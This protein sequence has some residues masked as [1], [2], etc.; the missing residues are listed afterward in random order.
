[1][2]RRLLQLDLH[3]LL[4]PSPNEILAQT[5]VACAAQDMICSIYTHPIGFFGHAPGPTIG[6]WDDQ[7]G[8]PVRGDWLL[9]PN[10]CYAIEGNVKSPVGAWGEQMVQIKLEQTACFD[11]ERVIYLAGR[12]TRWH[13]VR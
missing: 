8:T 5:R 3:H 4:A 11:G 7:D 13:V 6:M 10:T 1:E 9:H 12:Q 2:A